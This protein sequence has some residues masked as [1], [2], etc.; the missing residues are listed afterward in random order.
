MIG[1]CTL[2]GKRK[3]CQVENYAFLRW[4]SGS[5]LMAKT[6]KTKFVCWGAGTSKSRQKEAKSEVEM[7]KTIVIM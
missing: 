6:G 2:R 7:K 1:F 3:K 5:E 4:S